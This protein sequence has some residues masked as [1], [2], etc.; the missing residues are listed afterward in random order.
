MRESDPPAKRPAWQTALDFDGQSAS[1]Y[2]DYVNTSLFGLIEG[3]PR[4]VLELGCAGG[5]FGATLKQRFPGASVVGIEAGRAAA[6]VA[7]TRIDRVIHARIEDLD[8]DRE[9]LGLAEFDTVIVADVLEHVVNPWELLVRLKPRLAPRAQVIASIP[10][11]RNIWLVSQLLVGGRW[12]YTEHGLLDVTHLRFFTLEEI[13]RMFIETGYT[14]DTYQMSIL[15]SLAEF[16]R[17][18]EGKGAQMLKLG[19]LTLTDVSAD[20]LAQICAE[21][22]FLRCRPA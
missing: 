20:E 7:A 18:H 3:E 17:G 12:E 13:R 6:A 8:F 5:M 19:R 9:G 4:R 14:I 2:H 11:V 22:F 1:H 16:Y 21:Q 15:P 10:N